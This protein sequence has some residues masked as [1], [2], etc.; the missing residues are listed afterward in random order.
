MYA[1][2]SIVCFLV[3]QTLIVA[4]MVARSGR[5]GLSL[6]R[7]R[8]ASLLPMSATASTLHRDRSRL[9]VT[10]APSAFSHGQV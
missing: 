8:K 5:S 7:E 10:Q 9:T 4:L 6:T 2:V 1:I 3:V